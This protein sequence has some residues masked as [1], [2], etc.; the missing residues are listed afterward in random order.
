MAPSCNPSRAWHERFLFGPGR[1]QQIR[2]LQVSAD[3]PLEGH[4]LHS[5]CLLRGT[6]HAFSTTYSHERE[7]VAR[8]LLPSVGV[9]PNR[10]LPARLCPAAL[11]HESEGDPF[12]SQ[13]C[14]PNQPNYNLRFA[15]EGGMVMTLTYPCRSRLS[16]VMQPAGIKNVSGRSVGLTSRYVSLCA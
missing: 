7:V 10:L 14:S 1:C 15:S 11:E 8:L 9:N 4:N 12:L 5:Y 6:R 16:R 13:I 2:R 3:R